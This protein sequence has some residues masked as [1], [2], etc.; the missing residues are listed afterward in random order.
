MISG[1]L[2]KKFMDNFIAS[3]ED[4]TEKVKNQNL[5]IDVLANKI[6][7]E[8]KIVVVKG[9]TSKKADVY[10]YNG[11]KH[12]ICTDIQIKHIIRSYIPI[13]KATM[14]L[15]NSTLDLIICSAP[16]YSSYDYVKDIRY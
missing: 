6:I 13:G 8:N 4:L 10:V 16:L 11:R 14:Q 3:T 15:I 12:D 7:S 2:H 5:N 1:Q 9:Y